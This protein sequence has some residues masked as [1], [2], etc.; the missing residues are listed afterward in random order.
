[1]GDGVIKMRRWEILL[2]K[3][4]GIPLLRKVANGLNARDE[5]TT[6]VD[7]VMGHAINAVCDFLGAP[8]VIEET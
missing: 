4:V 5:N 2:L 6:G 8:D 1:M 7:D 3:M